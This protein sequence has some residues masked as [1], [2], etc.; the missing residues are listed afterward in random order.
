M[1]FNELNHQEKIEFKD[2][3][4]SYVEKFGGQH[5][6]YAALESI[7]EA[8]SHPLTNKTGKLH[9]SNGTIT[10]KKEIYKSKIDALKEAVRVVTSDNILDIEKDKL[11]KEVSNAVKTMANLEFLVEFKDNKL[12]SF[13]FK[14]FNSIKEEKAIINP[15]F[16]V[17]FFDS[18]P[19]IK[20]ILSY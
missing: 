20:K 11:K 3:L 13:T 16:Q 10:W 9:F 5:G 4:V 6:F 7:R 2:M 12:E 18:L 19:A 14:P 15:I 17:I 1:K 8:S